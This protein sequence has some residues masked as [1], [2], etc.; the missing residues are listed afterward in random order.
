MHQPHTRA[1]AAPAVDTTELVMVGAHGGAGTSTLSALLYGW[2]LGSIGNSIEPGRPPVRAHGRPLV[3][4]CRNTVP[5]ARYATAAVTA[6]ETWDER[7]AVLAIVSDGQP[8]PKDAVARFA[9]LAGRVGHLSRVPYVRALRLVDSPLDVK[10]PARAWGALMHL[11]A[12]AEAGPTA[13]G[14]PA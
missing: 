8:E 11:R 9:L 13:P 6:L 10:L 1:A 3:V 5:A 4:V 7:I 12:L 14:R 2:D